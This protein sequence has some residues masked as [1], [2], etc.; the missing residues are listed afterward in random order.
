MRQLW[1]PNAPHLCGTAARP[2]TGAQRAWHECL[3]LCWRL[4]RNLK[5]VIPILCK[6]EEVRFYEFVRNC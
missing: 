2:S 6:K 5:Y 1:K 4:L 3:P